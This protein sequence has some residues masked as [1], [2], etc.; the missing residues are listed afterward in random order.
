LPLTSAR[1]AER[2]KRPGTLKINTKRGRK[3]SPDDAPADE[4]QKESGC[5]PE[6]AR[7]YTGGRPA[8]GQS[9]EIPAKVKRKVNSGGETLRVNREREKT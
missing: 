4:V 9:W 5:V 8:P 3:I 7:T 1:N 6:E 2:K